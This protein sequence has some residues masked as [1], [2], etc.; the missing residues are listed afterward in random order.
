LLLGQIGRQLLD[1]VVDVHEAWG[2]PGQI[3]LGF[4]VVLFRLIFP[5][6]VLLGLDFLGFLLL[7]FALLLGVLF[8]GLVL[9]DLLIFV[10]L[11]AGRRLRTA[12]GVYTEKHSKDQGAYDDTSTHG[13]SPSF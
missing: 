8:P 6:L 3:L 13:R 11:L 4:L 12:A 2:L 7:G 5:G 10:A 1:E 9:L